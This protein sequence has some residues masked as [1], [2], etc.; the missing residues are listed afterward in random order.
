MLLDPDTWD[1]GAARRRGARGAWR[2]ARRATA[3]RRRTRAALELTTRPIA[4]V[5]GAIAELGRPARA[6]G[7]RRARDLGLATAGGGHAP[8]ADGR[9]PAGLAG[10][11][12]P[13]RAAH[14]ARDRSPRADVRAARAHRRGGP[15]ERDPAAQ[16]PARPSA[17][18][19]GA[20]GQ[21]AAVARPGDRVGLE[22]HDPLPG[23]PAHRPAAALR[24]TTR[25]GCAPSTCSCAQERSPS[26]PSCGGTCARSRGSAPS[27][28]A[29]WTRSRGWRRRAPCARSSRRWPG[30]S[31]RRATRRASSW[32]RRKRS[33]RTAS[34]PPA[35]ASR[36]SSSTPCTRRP[37]TGRRRA[38]RRPRRGHA[39]RR[40]SGRR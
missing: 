1:A 29:S 35:T 18:A 27:R 9:G 4:T 34:W 17:A 24:R 6:A 36:P 26:R 32:T 23:L 31:S 39:P 5:G 12:L 2:R 38:R 14:H 20:V 30:W 3:R 21:L 25:T 16:P 28:C 15:R 40:R 7:P 13:A 11:P 8:G 19:P 22:P 33:R 10:A 37:R